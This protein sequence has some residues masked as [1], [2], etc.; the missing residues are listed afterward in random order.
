MSSQTSGPGGAVDFRRRYGTLNGVADK[1]SRAVLDCI[2]EVPEPLIVE[3][4][5]G[6]G[7]TT[8]AVAASR[9]D[10]RVIGLDIS[11]ANIAAAN[12]LKAANAAGA[13]VE[14]VAA[15]FMTWPCPQADL[16]FCQSVL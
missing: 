4:G 1:V 10:A 3:I 11:P 13:R 7:E 12:S 6:T 5:C 2:S 16:L 9:S 15:D 8:L 14:F